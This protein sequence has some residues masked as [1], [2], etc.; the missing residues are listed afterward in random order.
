MIQNLSAKLCIFIGVASLSSAWSAGLIRDGITARSQ[1]M[2]GADVAAARSPIEAMTA[3]PAALTETKN[4]AAEISI[5]G[6]FLRA[7]LSRDHEKSA[8]LRNT[9]NFIGD[10]AVALPTGYSAV[11]WGLSASPSSIA[12]TDWR[13]RDREGGLDGKTT[14]G[15]IGHRSEFLAYDFR[16]GLGVDLTS[17]LSAGVAAGITYNHNFLNTAYIF[18]S[19]K[20]LKG[21]KTRLDLDTDGSA[22]SGQIG[23]TLKPASVFRISAAYT[24]PSEIHS[25]GHAQADLS[26]QLRSL[27][28]GFASVDPQLNADAEVLTKLPQK[29]TTGIAWQVTPEL[30]FSSEFEWI[31]WSSAFDELPVTLSHSSNDAVNQLVGSDRFTDVVPLHWRDQKVIRVGVEWELDPHWSLRGGFAHSSR[32]V[33]SETLTPLSSAIDDTIV[34]L[35]TG[36]RRDHW[37]LDFSWQWHLP[38]TRTVSN[39]ILKTGEYDHSRLE[40]ESHWL[41]LTYGLDF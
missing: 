25:K 16:A 37:H 40:L 11:R 21:F 23:I 38:K 31:G 24:L 32:V 6:V 30:L 10:I 18:Q 12:A 33:P 36:Y 20:T 9:A 8:R 27:G 5:D 35:G 15:N 1:A 2:G 17:W 28:G 29:F 22:A 7:K 13:Y 4:V 39:S 26:A 3:N 34:S 14:Y 41:G 19:Q